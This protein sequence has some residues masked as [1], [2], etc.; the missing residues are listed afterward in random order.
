M[1]HPF[2]RRL[3]AK[4]FLMLRERR[5][6]HLEV[7]F[8]LNIL[9]ALVLLGA[10]FESLAPITCPPGCLANTHPWF[11]AG[12]CHCTHFQV[13]C[14]KLNISSDDQMDAILEKLD[15]DL[16]VLHVVDC[17]LQ[18]GLTRK[19]LKDLTNL[20]MLRIEF[21]NLTT[22][23][24]EYVLPPSLQVLEL[25]YTQLQTVNY[26]YFML[27]RALWTLPPS[28]ASLSID[29]SSIFNLPLNLSWPQL[30]DVNV[31]HLRITHSN[32]TDV[33]PLTAFTQL[34]HLNLKYNNITTLPASLPPTLN[35][36]DISNNQI[37]SLPQ[38][39]INGFLAKPFKIV[40]ASNPISTLDK[41]VIVHTILNDW[42]DIAETPLCNSLYNLL[43]TS[44]H[45]R[46]CYTTCALY[47]PKAAL[48]DFLPDKECYNVACSFDLGDFSTVL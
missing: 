33:P 41:S 21:T 48:G 38:T 13:N 32:L 28:L 11:A 29:H 34:A 23:D 35:Y 24:Y 12:N 22:W 46:I 7:Y 9:W 8:F 31:I 2:M 43:P 26:F 30:I 15:G 17:D 5:K 42:V 4:S 36:L 27:P 40:L 1:S 10:V 18:N 47:C 19:A 3:S 39:V 14:K 37:T 20:F 16:L 45:N 44:Q 25:R 6:I